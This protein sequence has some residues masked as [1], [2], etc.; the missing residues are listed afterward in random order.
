MAV[1]GFEAYRMRHTQTVYDLTSLLT[2][3]VVF[4]FHRNREALNPVV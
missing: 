3:S 4:F 2:I 1:R